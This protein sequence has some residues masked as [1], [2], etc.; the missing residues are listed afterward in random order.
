[1]PIGNNTLASALIL[2]LGITGC[3]H[4][5]PVNRIAT[6]YNRAMAMSRD[7]Q[8]L[9]NVLRAGSRSPFM[10]TA[11]G[12]VTGT[13]NDSVKLSTV[14]S[15][16]IAGGANVI[17]PTLDMSGSTTPVVK[18]VPLSSKEFTEGIMRPIKPEVLSFFVGQGWDKEFLLPLVLAGYRCKD[19]EEPDSLNWYDADRVA[20]WASSL[21]LRKIDTKPLAAG[22]DVMLSLTDGQ[23]LDMLKSTA[24]G[25]ISV[26]AVREGNEADKAVVVLESP[27]KSWQAELPGICANKENFELESPGSAESALRLRSVEAILYYLGEAIRPCLLGQSKDCSI[28]YSKMLRKDHQGDDRERDCFLAAGRKLEGDRSWRYLFRLRSGSRAP[29]TAAIATEYRGAYYWIDRLD[30]CD[31]DRTLKTLSFLSQMIALQT[32]PG[33]VAV[34]PSVISL[35][36][37]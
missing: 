26:K 37:P 20:A 24:A 18:V 28:S 22:G 21:K 35:G 19:G 30:R 27:T 8:L 23:A 36:G 29:A 25:G 31:T 14:A 7:E 9:L 6:D 10:F 32:S 11:I 17:S 2:A 13:A 5:G 4:S 34:T 1:M 3:S 33:D 15:N 12:E 16:L